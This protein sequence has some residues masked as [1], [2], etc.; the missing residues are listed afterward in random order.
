MTM[1]TSA[2]RS[3][4]KIV[5][6]GKKKCVWMEAGV[7][8][9]KLCDN[10]YDCSTCQYDH[11]MQAKAEKSRSATTAQPMAPAADK[12]TATWV[13]AMMMLPADRR[14]CRYMLTGEVGRK[15]CPNAYDCG[16]CA[17]DQ[18]MQERLQAEVLPVSV[19]ADASGFDLARD[20]YYHEGHTWARPEYGGRVRVGLDDFARR[21]IGQGCRVELPRIGQAVTQGQA[22]FNLRRNGDI[23]AALAP[24][25]GV[26][27]HINTRLVDQPELI[28]TSPYEGGWLFIVEP[29]KLRTNLKGLFYGEE[30]GTF[31][32][33]EKDKLL[34]LANQDLGLAAD[35][36]ETVEDVSKDLKGQNWA[37][38]VG[39][40]L[41]S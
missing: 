11:A 14:K 6:P 27:S 2:K 23:V 34:A 26:V 10:N 37:K 19:Q 7:V 30:A 36:G 33:Q 21:L 39:A 17:F 35:G 18:M 1:E 22:G 41:R 13:E 3:A 38:V 40:F 24:I 5:P 12:V 20:V 4:M 29:T 15:I 16:T 32:R 8:S 31:M 25:D 9:Y 28:N